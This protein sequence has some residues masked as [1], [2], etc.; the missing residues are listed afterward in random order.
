MGYWIGVFAGMLLSVIIMYFV[1]S[2]RKCTI[3]QQAT[4]NDFCVKDG[5]KTKPGKLRRWLSDYLRV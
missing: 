4:I 3:C 1:V 5:G 2:I